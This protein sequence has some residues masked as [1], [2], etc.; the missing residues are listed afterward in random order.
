LNPAIISGVAVVR[1]LS[2]L[3]TALSFFAFAASAAAQ[4]SAIFPLDHFWSHALDAP[5]AAAPAADGRH[6][7]VPLQT[8]RLSAIDPASNAVVW[9]VELAATGPLLAD[10][11]RVFVPA[12]GAVHAL[13]AATGALAWRVP[14][15]ALSAPLA[16][17]GGWLVV[18]LADGAVQGVRA[19][20]GSVVWARS[21][22][23]PVASAPSI[24][25]DVLAV[26]LADGRVVA[27]H[28]GTGATLWER[29]L[30]SI[31]SGLT[32]SGDRVFAGTNDGF[33]WALRTRDGAV[34][35]RWR[36]GSRFIGAAAVDANGV[37]AV[38]VDNVVRGFRRGNGN[39]RWSHALTTR[40]LAGPMI[41]DGLL[42]ITTAEVGK[43][44]LLYVR[45]DT[46]AGAGRTP[47]LPVVNETMRVQFPALITLDA[48]PR[49]ILASAT[50]GGDWTLHAYRQTFLTSTP[51]VL[52]WGPKYDIRLRLDYAIGIR[53]FGTGLPLVPLVPPVPGVPLV[54][55]VPGVPK[56]R[57]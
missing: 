15:A 34:D 51:G 31:A 17:R 25:G 1:A 55:K 42:V 30:G 39:Q 21:L 28:V 18:A 7:Y 5:F 26:G 32:L 33:F 10:D 12:A 22:G 35:W 46:G 44:G 36:T 16:H 43:P 56:V 41:V 2:N 23:S 45:P 54:P 48:E 27:M 6:V 38:A 8:G 24:D 14:A 40:A 37:Y 49:A 57:F 53:V 20:D 47:P 29:P 50:P 4:T 13:D 11:G 9:S 52:A 19:A 3:L